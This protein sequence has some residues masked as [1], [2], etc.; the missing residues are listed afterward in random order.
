MGS[1][2]YVLGSLFVS[3]LGAS[4]MHRGEG[5]SQ[6]KDK[7]KTVTNPS[8]GEVSKKTDTEVPAEFWS[9]ERK[10]SNASFYYL[11]GEY[12]LMN[13][14][15]GGAAKL[16]ETA[17]NMEPNAFVGSKLI[18]SKSLSNFD[19]SLTLA[20]KMSLLYPNNPD[21][22]LSY[23]RLLAA[24]GEMKDAETY[25]RSAVKLRPENLEGSVLLIQLLQ[26]QNKT[27]EA[28]VVAKAMVERNGDFVEG[29]ALLARLYLVNNQAANAVAPARKAY[30]LNSTDSEK[31]HLLA[32]SLLLGKQT[33]QAL[34]YFDSLIK[35]ENF[36]DDS[37]EKMLKLYE[38]IGANKVYLKDF[39]RADKETAKKSDGLS[40]Q[41]AVLEWGKQNFSDSSQIL[42]DL[43]KR[44]PQNEKLSYLLALTREKNGQADEAL[45]VY[46]SFDTKSDLYSVTRVRAIDLLK[47]LG[48]TEDALKVAN[49]A[50]DTKNEQSVVFY[51]LASNLLSNTNR[52]DEAIALVNKGLVTDPG[53]VELLFL[54]AVFLEK[55]KKLEDSIATL[56][57]V[58][59]RDP[60]HAAA[61]NYLGY[62]YAERNIH[63]DDAEKLIKR[64]LDEKPENGFYLDSLGWVYYQQKRYSESVAALEKALQLSNNDPTI[65]EHLGDA[66]VKVGDAQKAQ[67]AYKLFLDNVKDPKDLE[68]VKAKYDMANSA[69]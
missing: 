56:Q 47:R 13:R 21:I 61:L 55:A 67:A 16:F 39:Q 51:S 11:A 48:R 2:R 36:S 28:I 23:G 18:E 10:K 9:P 63:L 45:K 44:Y 24:K 26:A 49:E 57:E 60:K 53:N 8:T 30:D 52:N 66:Y 17:Y 12:E 40:F 25:L 69:D 37:I 14:N 29:W 4:C 54:K 27:K 50:I 59:K 65:S 43:A 68:R 32:V 31:I 1:N 41:M 46:L 33:K 20:K 19:E 5:E 58:I 38:E 34:T 22:Q 42:A 3:L 6:D 7:N 35:P 15:A 64:A 62:M